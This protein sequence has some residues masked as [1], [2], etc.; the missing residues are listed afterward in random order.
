M[1]IRR[2]FIAGLLL[3]GLV[4][5]YVYQ[6]ITKATMHIDF[7]GVTLP[8]LPIAAWV[9]VAMG[10][11][12]A[13]T[14]FHMVFYS[15]VGS[16]RLRRFQKDFDHLREAVIDA[17]LKKADREH[18][19]KTERYALLGHL[20]DHTDMEPQEDIGHIA[21]EKIS[22]VVQ[23]I[24][25]VRRGEVADLNKFNLPVD[26]PL[27]HRNLLN[28]YRAG[29]LSDEEILSK[30]EEY[31]KDLCQTAYEHLV[32]E[33]T[34]HDIEKY[35]EFMTFDALKTVLERINADENTINLPNATLIDF[36]ERIGDLTS[37]DY[38]YLATV[39]ADHMLPE[40]RIKLFESLSEKDDKAL[41]AYL[42]TLFDLEMIDKAKELLETTTGDEYQLFKAYAELKGCSKHYDIKIF[43]RM[44]LQGYGKKS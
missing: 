22:T 8:S 43:A 41:D 29:E 5:G 1:Y 28:R 11:L 15:I 24:F 36:F 19:F 4:G 18:I 17:Y 16:F 33:G 20:V 3:I 6:Y 7:F 37:L 26:N 12:F 10:L 34:V 39:V 21:D 44:M 13:A 40:Q 31:P 35:R 2:Y 30:C 14:L 25:Q 38:L 9:A 42:L 23:T 27:M 32:V